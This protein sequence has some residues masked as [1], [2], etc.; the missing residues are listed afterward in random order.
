LFAITLSLTALVRASICY[1]D[2]V[3]HPSRQPLFDRSSLGD[4]QHPLGLVEN[5]MSGRELS[6]EGN[7]LFAF[8]SMIG[9]A[10]FVV[11]VPLALVIIWLCS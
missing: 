1:T 10:I 6:Y 9:N 7:L 4:G 5:G 8:A 11:G 2:T 3:T